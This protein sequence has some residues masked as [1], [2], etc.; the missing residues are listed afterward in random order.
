MP[1]KKLLVFAR[2]IYDYILYSYEH[3]C[4]HI[5]YS[6]QNF[7]ASRAECKDF[8]SLRGIYIHIYC[9]YVNIYIYIYCNSSR[10]LAA[11]RAEC[12]DF[13]S[14]REIYIHRYCIYMNTYIY[15]LYSSRNFAA[16][17]AEC[18]IS[19]VVHQGH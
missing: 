13:E 16:S 15:I 19:E 10:I 8:E 2:N 14:L 5:L 17:R 3:I 1:Q 12:K 18:K 6:S 7:A 11:S 9:I 4:I